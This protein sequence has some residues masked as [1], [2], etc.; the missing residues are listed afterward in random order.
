MCYH[1]IS[2]H[3]LI[4]C[5]QFQRLI[6]ILSTDNVLVALYVRWKETRWVQGSCPSY[7]SLPSSSSHSIW[8]KS[9]PV[10]AIFKV[11]QSLPWQQAILTADA[12]TCL[13]SWPGQLII[14]C[15]RFWLA[16]HIDWPFDQLPCPDWP[17]AGSD[18]LHEQCRHMGM[19]MGTLVTQVC[20]Q[21]R[22]CV[23]V[24]V[25][26]AQLGDRVARVW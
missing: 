22:H 18:Y 24:V 5:C 21:P 4:F 20:P 2:L 3:V 8:P 7:K 6:L 1:D 25:V 19:P 15:L 16:L 11:V 12:Y 17:L 9:L 10:L 26:V 23:V 14:N 13:A